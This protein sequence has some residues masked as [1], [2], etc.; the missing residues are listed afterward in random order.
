MKWSSTRPIDLRRQ[1][2]G[3]ATAAGWSIERTLSLPPETPTGS[4]LVTGGE[5]RGPAVLTLGLLTEDGT[6]PVERPQIVSEH[7]PRA[8]A[9]P[10]A[11][12]VRGRTVVAAVAEHPPRGTLADLLARDP[13]PAAGE[14]VTILA[15]VARALADIHGSGWAGV[16]LRTDDVA[17]RADGCPVVTGIDRL[18]RFQ[19]VTA[20]ADLQLYAELASAVC[21]AVGGSSGAAL[22]RA[23]IGDRHRSWDDVIRALVGT[24]DPTAI[25]G[26]RA[27]APGETRRSSPMTRP[28]EGGKGEPTVP[29]ARGREPNRTGPHASVTELEA[30]V[31][32]SSLARPGAPSSGRPVRADRVSGCRPSRERESAVGSSPGARPVTGVERMLEEVADRPVARAVAAVRDWIAARPMVAVVA[33]VPLIA[34]VLVLILT[35]A[36]PGGVEGAGGGPLSLVAGVEST[37]APVRASGTGPGD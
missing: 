25:S 24:A 8:L 32:R 11:R 15:G 16:V 27:E 33:A 17:F 22:I 10:D 4:F 9:P 18:G 21:A 5:L 34:V 7:V 31:L 19:R 12:I 23:A 35:P 1:A 3:F 30:T 26:G 29:R 36:G 28:L 14:A 37:P 20:Q 13:T 2:V 6:S